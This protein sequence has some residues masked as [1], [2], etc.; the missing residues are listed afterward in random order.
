[1]STLDEITKEKQQISEALA[2]V[3]MQREKLANQL[4]ELEATERVLA[5]Y[6]KGTRL[7]QTAYDDPTTY[8]GDSTPL[9]HTRSY[10]W[11]PPL[12]DIIGA[13]LPLPPREI[14]TVRQRRRVSGTTDRRL[15]CIAPG[16][17]TPKEFLLIAHLRRSCL[18]HT[19]PRLTLRSFARRRVSTRGVWQKPK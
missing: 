7:K 3:E 2:R 6:T 1:M 12:N 13:L 8:T 15:G 4:G 17:H 10:E 14:S 19:L 9:A 18:L 11:C 5:R 16:S